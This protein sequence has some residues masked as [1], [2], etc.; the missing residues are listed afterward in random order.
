MRNKENKISIRKFTGSFYH[1]L[2]DGYSMEFISVIDYVSLNYYR[3]VP[4]HRF[5][6][7]LLY[8]MITERILAEYV[9]FT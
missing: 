5:Q 6:T 3:K 2:L 7:L 4:Y 1:Q 8:E 9:T